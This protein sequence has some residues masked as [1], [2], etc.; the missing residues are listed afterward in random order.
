MKK[1][2]RQLS[3]RLPEHLLLEIIQA[4][5]ERNETKSVFVKKSI[6][7]FLDYYKRVQ[8]PHLTHQNIFADLK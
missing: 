8:R 4:A 1:Q 6:I 2:N 3:L 5:E 7:A